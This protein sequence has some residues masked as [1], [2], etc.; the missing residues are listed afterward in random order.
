MWER[1]H[2]QQ[3]T[4]SWGSWHFWVSS[5]KRLL[6][7]RDA[8]NLRECW[9]TCHLV[10]LLLGAVN[11]AYLCH[12]GLILKSLGHREWFCTEAAGPMGIMWSTFPGCRRTKGRLAKDKQELAFFLHWYR[13]HQDVRWRKVSRQVHGEPL[14]VAAERSW[15]RT[16]ACAGWLPP[17]AAVPP[18][19]AA[20]I[21]DSNSGGCLQGWDR[22]VRCLNEK[23]CRKE[24]HSGR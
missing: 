24:K 14:K 16:A 19:L 2:Q 11:E 1:L 4:W 7:C 23:S 10:T 15:M 3:P 13:R 6:L 21:A 12:K 8:N 17:T 9:K 22:K 20:G 5:D 18:S